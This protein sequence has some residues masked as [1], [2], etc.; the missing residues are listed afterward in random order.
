MDLKT[1]HA[2]L[3]YTDIAGFINPQSEK[4]AE[5]IR[6]HIA[7]NLTCLEPLAH[8]AYDNPF[9]IRHWMQ[10]PAQKGWLFIQATPGQWPRLKSLF[11]CWLSIAMKGRREHQLLPQQRVWFM[12]EDLACLD[13][14]PE[15]LSFLAEGDR[16]NSCVV[17]GVHDMPRLG[18]SYGHHIMQSLFDVCATKVLFRCS[19]LMAQKFSDMMWASEQHRKS[20]FSPYALTHLPDFVA[21]VQLPQGYPV[22]LVN[23]SRP[24]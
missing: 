12:I 20:W 19:S 23:W 8:T 10:D 17:L 11:S 13:K 7:A 6:K 14:L 1:L 21:L 16:H 15:L 5:N 18:V 22:M 9:S 4:S 24:V 2:K 3:S